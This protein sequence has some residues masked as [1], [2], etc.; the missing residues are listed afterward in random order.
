M[1]CPLAVFLNYEINNL[2]NK[3]RRCRRIRFSISSI[4]FKNSSPIRIIL[5]ICSTSQTASS[6]SSSTSLFHYTPSLTSPQSLQ[7]PLAS[8]P[9]SHSPSLFRFRWYS[10]SQRRSKSTSEISFYS[11]DLLFLPF[12]R[13]DSFKVPI[14][15]S[16]HLLSPQFA[17]SSSV[18]FLIFWANS[19]YMKIKGTIPSRCSKLV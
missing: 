12:S 15:P 7:D 16:S 13:F 18:R 8:S 3:I 6:T 2:N 10:S 1:S 19:Y 5:P 11:S 14:P 9:Y 17:S 4:I